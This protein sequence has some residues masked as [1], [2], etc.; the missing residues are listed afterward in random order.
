MANTVSTSAA[1][2]TSGRRVAS[3]DCPELW[4]G[5]GSATALADT[6]P[7]SSVLT[8]LNLQHNKIGDAGATALADALPANSV[9]TEL[10]LGY[11]KI[12]D[13]G[14]TAL[15][16]ALESNTSLTT[17]SIPDIKKTEVLSKVKTKLEANKAWRKRFSDVDWRVPRAAEHAVNS[18]DSLR[19][20][21]PPR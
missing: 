10:N 18:F 13:A 5:A 19:S 15:A 21:N 9:L 4:S 8:E 12:G 3:P 14:A 7:A 20:G 6:L 11:N 1:R 2:A 17:L 16:D